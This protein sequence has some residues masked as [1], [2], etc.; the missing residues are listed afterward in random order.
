M[1]IPN[2]TTVPHLT[3]IPSQSS[4]PYMLLSLVAVVRSSRSVER[5]SW[6]LLSRRR[7]L[8]WLRGLSWRRCERSRGVT[9]QL[10]PVWR[11]SSSVEWPVRRRN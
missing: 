4:T 1:A 10:V 8:R 2:I 6:E 7:V 11:D 9:Q 5:V 3:S